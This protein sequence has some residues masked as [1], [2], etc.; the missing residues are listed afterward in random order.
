MSTSTQVGLTALTQ[1]VADISAAVAN[2]GNAIAQAVADFAATGSNSE[3]PA[4]Q[5]LAANIETQ[6][7]ALNTATG[8]LN[9]ALTPPAGTVASSQVKKSIL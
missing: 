9:A 4:V 1:A 8:N 2:A 5:T 6:V 3:D 7:A